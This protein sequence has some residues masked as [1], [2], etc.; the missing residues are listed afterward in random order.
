MRTGLY[1]E[2]TIGNIIKY[3]YISFKS[4]GRIKKFA[5]FLRLCLLLDFRA[6][7]GRG[8]SFH[9]PNWNE[10]CQLCLP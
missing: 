4:H 6:N 1:S 7:Y 3:N 8:E 2:L 9:I 10:F 5:F